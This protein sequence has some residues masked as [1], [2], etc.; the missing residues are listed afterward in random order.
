MTLNLKNKK[1]LHTHAQKRET[2]EVTLGL[3]A[4]GPLSRTEAASSGL[5]SKPKERGG[6]ALCFGASLSTDHCEK[7]KNDVQEIQR[8]SVSVI[9][10][11]F[12]RHFQTVLSQKTS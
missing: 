7:N 12:V 10:D 6:W 9:F 3:S 4:G 2:G 1:T 11:S 5:K 8:F